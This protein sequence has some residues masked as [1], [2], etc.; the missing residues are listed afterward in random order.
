MRPPFLFGFGGHSERSSQWVAWAADTTYTLEPA[1][2]AGNDD[3]GTLAAWYVF[4]AAGL[5][6][7]TCTGRYTLTA[8]L[9]DRVVWHLSDGDLDIR[10]APVD[11]AAPT[12]DGVPWEEPT[13][14]HASIAGGALITV[15]AP[16]EGP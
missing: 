12:L 3:G 8:P 14:P 6:P 9:F 7:L 5:Y 10:L 11:Q 15:P 16:P 1:G 2:L 4:A 13:I